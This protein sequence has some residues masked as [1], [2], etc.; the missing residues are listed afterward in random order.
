MSFRTGILLLWLIA[1]L[2]IFLILRWVGSYKVPE[3]I[4]E[5]CSPNIEAAMD[6]MGPRYNYKMIGETLYVNKGDGKW[7]RLRYERR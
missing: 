3:F 5:V 2:S 4:G 7:L 1:L 6:K